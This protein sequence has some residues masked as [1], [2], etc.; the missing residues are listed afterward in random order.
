LNQ[1][2][3]KKIGEESGR[4]SPT[5]KG[6]KDGNHPVVKKVCK[7]NLKKKRGQ[8]ERAEPGGKA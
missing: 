7:Q 6:R 1:R 2:K 5:H 3:K 4:E 8:K